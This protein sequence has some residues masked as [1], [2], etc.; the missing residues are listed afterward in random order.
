MTS[1]E[2]NTAL[3][4]NGNFSKNKS[5]FTVE[6]YETDIVLSKENDQ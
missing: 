3:Y 5:A 6:Q 2:A 4:D 1:E